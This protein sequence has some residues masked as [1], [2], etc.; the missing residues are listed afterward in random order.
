MLIPLLLA[1]AT[2]LEKKE[3]V[4]IFH[5]AWEQA[6]E[7]VSESLVSKKDCGNIKL[8]RQACV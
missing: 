5:F 4:S 7:T 1:F 3:N 8:D 2:L 6:F